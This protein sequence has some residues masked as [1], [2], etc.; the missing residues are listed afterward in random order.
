MAKWYQQNKNKFKNN[1]MCKERS[2][3][4]TNFIQEYSQY[5]NK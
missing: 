2:N 3:T 5:L 1:K 4:W